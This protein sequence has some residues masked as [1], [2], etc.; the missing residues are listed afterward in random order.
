MNGHAPSL[1]REAIDLLVAALTKLI[2][3]EVAASKAQTKT[4]ETA[5]HVRSG[6]GNLA[7]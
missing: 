2:A 3:A 4:R 6:N 5:D 7:P 1:V